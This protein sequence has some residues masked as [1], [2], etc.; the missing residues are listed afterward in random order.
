[1]LV[2]LVLVITETRG[3]RINNVN[4]QPLARSYS[5]T[6]LTLDQTWPEPVKLVD[7]LTLFRLHVHNGSDGQM[8]ITIRLNR[9]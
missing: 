9:N 3:S 6:L 7:P 4:N 1:M 5:S 2:M 8:Q